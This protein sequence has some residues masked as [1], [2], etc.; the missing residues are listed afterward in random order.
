MG[1]GRN[2]TVVLVRSRGLC[3]LRIRVRRRAHFGLWTRAPF[4]FHGLAIRLICARA[5]GYAE[6]FVRIEPNA[7]S[8]VIEGSALYRACAIHHEAG[9]LVRWMASQGKGT[10]IV[11]YKVPAALDTQ[12]HLI[13]AHEVT[14]RRLDPAS[15]QTDVRAGAR[16]ARI[17]GAHCTGRSR[18]LQRRGDQGLRRCRDRAGSTRCSD[19]STPIQRRADATAN[20]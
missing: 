15:A 9:T 20:R 4:F 19:G 12:R 16:G 18:L 2:R 17:A 1:L 8:D 6:S 7:P 13:V 10:G 14:N 5:H 3:A 11:G